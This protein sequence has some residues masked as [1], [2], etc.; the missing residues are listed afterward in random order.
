MKK[1]ATA[2]LIVCLYN[3]SNSNAQTVTL[4]EKSIE[5]EKLFK[6][7]EKQ[8]GYYFIYRD[9]WLKN[10]KKVD[11]KVKDV[12]LIDALEICFRNQQFTFSIVDKVIVL[13]RKPVPVVKPFF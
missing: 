1:L 5:L 4:T 3:I 8:T 2:F 10:A 9:E 6:K 7:I 12:L 11:I 13:K